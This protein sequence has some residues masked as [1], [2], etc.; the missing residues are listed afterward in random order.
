MKLYDKYEEYEKFEKQYKNLSE[1]CQRIISMFM[2]R[3]QHDFSRDDGNISERLK[4]LQGDLTCAEFADKVGVNMEALKK[5]RQRQAKT[6]RDSDI[7]AKALDITE[8]ELYHEEHE[9]D[10]QSRI[11]YDLKENFLQQPETTQQAL[12]FLVEQL[13]ILEN[14]P[15]YFDNSLNE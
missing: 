1:S 4:K 9:V 15:E 3:L 14:C 7:I 5:N 10:Y 13:N 8:Y 2:H 12:I 11:I 6:M